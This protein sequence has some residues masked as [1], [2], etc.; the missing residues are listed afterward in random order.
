MTAWDRPAIFAALAIA[1]LS[2][3]SCAH[4]QERPAPYA[5]L[6]EVERTF[7]PLLTAGNHPTVDQYGTGERVGLFKDPS[8]TI[9][10]LP[11][12]VDGNA[13]V[14]ACAPPA[15]RNAKV[16][17]SFD[18]ASSVIGST[19]QPTGWRG[20]TGDLELLLRDKRGT[21]RWQAVHGADLPGDPVCWAPEFPGPRQRLHYYRLAPSP[22]GAQDHSLRS[23][24]TN[25]KSAVFRNV[26]CSKH[27][28]PKMFRPNVLQLLTVAAPM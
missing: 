28:A 22:A 6:A 4:R 18:A 26:S 8:G 19:N 2:S 17:D 24:K 11:I 21:I 13:A 23:C 3:C 16:T 7:G 20:G 25:G 10:G 14:L 15:L 12:S 27:V 1:A 9:W 5:R